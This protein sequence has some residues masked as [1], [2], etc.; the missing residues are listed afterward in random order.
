VWIF[1]TALFT[2][3]SMSIMAFGPIVSAFSGSH[4]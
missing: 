2:A 1:V 4:S 3:P